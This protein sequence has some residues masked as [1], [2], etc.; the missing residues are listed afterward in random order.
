MNGKIRSQTI[1]PKKDIQLSTH[2]TL[3]ELC[4][5][6]TAAR[7]GINNIATDPKHIHNLELL[8]INILEPIRYMIKKPFAPTSGYRT[9]E[10]NDYIGGA[11]NSQHMVGEAVDLDAISGV[12]NKDLFHIIER[13]LSGCYDQ[14]IMELPGSNP[15]DGWIHVS[16]R[17]RDNRGQKLLW[18]GKSYSII[19]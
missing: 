17:Q 6:S 7:K 14:L 4:R 2:F 18:D 5:S 1:S 15:W 16:H 19:P 13:M 10:L 3:F 8:C 11:K 9:K 12:S